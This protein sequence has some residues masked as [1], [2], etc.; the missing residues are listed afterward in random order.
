MKSV[1]TRAGRRMLSVVD[2]HCAGEPARV[3]VG[4][5]ADVPGATMFEK[6]QYF[7]RNHDDIRKLL[8]KEPRGYP[9]QNIDVLLSPTNPACDAGFIIG[10]QIEYA[11]MSGHNTICT[12]TVLLETGI[13]PMIE[14]VTELKLDT[15]AGL[16]QVRATC[17]NGKV[18][19]VTF[20]NVPC[21]ATHLDVE[22]DVPGLG[23][24]VV[25]VAWGGMMFALVDSEK[26]GVEIAPENGRELVRL[27]EMV[28]IAAKEQ[29]SIVHP[30]NPEIKDIS[31]IVIRGP[32]RNPEAAAQNCVVV[33]TGELKW[34]KPETFV[35]AIDRSPCGTGTC[36]AMAV[37]YAKGLLKIGEPFIHESTIGTLF[38]GVLTEEIKVGEYNAV[39]PEITG[40]AWITG[41]CT[42]VLE[43]TDPFPEG[44][45]IGDI[46]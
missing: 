18:T 41:Y 23:K 1:V 38:T 12:V 44:F 6:M 46:W 20:A 13:V 14:P 16:V 21:F 45:T 31:I 27:G 9:A 11:P 42:I 17:A 2:A 4:G 35:G 19:G 3:V 22:V 34:D 7:E 40:Q 43:K 26:L 8:V 29:L 30:D 33:S 10:E 39:V 28:K 37:R 36:A 5:V 15:P 25:D 32:A 24:V